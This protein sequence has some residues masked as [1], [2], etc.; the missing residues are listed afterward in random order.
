[1]LQDQVVDQLRRIGEQLTRQ[2]EVEVCRD[3]VVR[4]N[5]AA[6]FTQ[7]MGRGDSSGS[8]RTRGS[9]TGSRKGA[10][11]RKGTA[12]GSGKARAAS[13]D[14]VGSSRKTY[15]RQLTEVCKEYT[16]SQYWLQDRG[17]WLLVPSTV[18]RGLDRRALFLVAIPYDFDI[19]TVSAWGFWDRNDGAETQWI[20]PRHTNYPTGSICAFHLGDE[21]PWHNGGSLV[22][23]LDLYSEWALRHLYLEHFHRWP[24]SQIASSTY[25]RM[26]ETHPEELCGCGST[27]KTYAECHQPAD[28]ACNRVSIALNFMKRTSGGRRDPPIELFDVLSGKRGPPPVVGYVMRTVRTDPGQVEAPTAR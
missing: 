12:G 6:A 1:M 15:D 26:V 11:G 5:E 9:A 27:D 21:S 22:T 13:P 25:E 14:V 10:A 7:P 2:M 24:G 4:P 23:L 28:L 3:G 16:G 20:G 17:L 18:L 8:E 19:A